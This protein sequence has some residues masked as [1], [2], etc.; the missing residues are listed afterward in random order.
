M[1]I[2]C[3]VT[4]FINEVIKKGEYRFLFHY[5]VVIDIGANIGTFSMF[6]YDFADKIYAIEPA[7]DNYDLLSKNVKENNLTKIKTFKEAIA[8]NTGTREMRMSGSAG[9]GGWNIVDYTGPKDEYQPT[10]AITLEGFMEREKIDYIDLVKIDTEGAE[11]EMFEDTTFPFDKIGTIICEFHHSNY[12]EKD[13]GFYKSI[14]EGKGFT[15]HE[16]SNKFLAR[17]K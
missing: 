1:I 6:I 9:G 7:P 8:C 11:K 14:L 16:T 17:K 5:P 13:R 3:N 10:R 12:S 2:R 15:Y 4:R